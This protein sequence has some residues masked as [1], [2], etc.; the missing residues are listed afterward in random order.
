M[1]NL[2]WPGPVEFLPV[3]QA[4]GVLMA[5][6]TAICSGLYRQS[7]WRLLDSGEVTN[8]SELAR[9][10]KLEPGW[11]AEVLRM[12]MLAPDIVQA[13]VEGR[14]PRNLNLHAVRGRQAEVPL[15]WQE[16]RVLFGFQDS[17][18]KLSAVVNVDA[19]GGRPGNEDASA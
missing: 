6:I 16:Q 8:A 5:G 14:Q 9:R 13:I 19:N 1:E 4:L 7:V 17:G 3:C 18:R 10:F 11:V 2:G 12:T 15:D